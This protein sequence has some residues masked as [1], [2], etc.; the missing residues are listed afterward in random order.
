MADRMP[1]S[2][3]QTPA[4]AEISNEISAPRASLLR[5]LEPW[6]IRNLPPGISRN[7]FPEILPR[8]YVKLYGITLACRH[9]MYV[10]KLH[11]IIF[12]VDM[13][14][15]SCLSRSRNDEKNVA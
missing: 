4:R 8:I 10:V 7:F 15:E 13:Y 2:E 14:E 5:R 3:V 11:L 12:H 1:R 6:G 9:I